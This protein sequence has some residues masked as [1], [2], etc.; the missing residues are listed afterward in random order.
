[1]NMGVNADADIEVP[2][3]TFVN[4]VLFVTSRGT[5]SSGEPRNLPRKISFGS[6]QRT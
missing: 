6:P 4:L 3:C 5:H 1:M 2:A